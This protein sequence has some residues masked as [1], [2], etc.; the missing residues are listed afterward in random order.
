MQE[1]AK[2][3]KAIIRGY[4]EEIWNRGLIERFGNFFAA[5]YQEAAY[6][7]ASSEGHCA[8]VA[9]QKRIMPDAVWTIERMAAEDDGV[10]CELTLRGTHQAAFKGVEPSGNPIRVRAYRTFVLKDGKIVHHSALL[11]TAELLKQ[12]QGQQAA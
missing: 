7:P 11:D 3:N 4:L 1:Q 12:M 6:S 10:M 2:A 8:M 5:N 9:V